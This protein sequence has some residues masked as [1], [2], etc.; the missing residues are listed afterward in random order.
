[1][2]NRMLQGFRNKM[3]LIQWFTIIVVIS[4]SSANPCADKSNA[5]VDS[6]SEYA[7][8][9][10]TAS[11]CR[12]E[13]IDTVIIEKVIPLCSCSV[14]SN[15]IGEN[16]GL[17]TPELVSAYPVLFQIQTLLYVL[18]QLRYS[19]TAIGRVIHAVY[20]HALRMKRAPSP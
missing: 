13:I 18:L 14:G 10:A 11:I 12:N 19:N 9:G 16:D 6:I 3:V 4:F 7:Y 17:Y 20:Q 2:N 8:G 15:C 1:M 5:Y